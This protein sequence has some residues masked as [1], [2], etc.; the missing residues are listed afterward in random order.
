M[1]ANWWKQGKR[2]TEFIVIKPLPAGCNDHDKA[3]Q[4]S[5]KL[6]NAMKASGQ[7][8]FTTEICTA[9]SFTR[10]AKTDDVER[11]LDLGLG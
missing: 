7:L 9:L 3:S 11:V 1:F 5:T 4:A 2:H 6:T 10:R 8:I